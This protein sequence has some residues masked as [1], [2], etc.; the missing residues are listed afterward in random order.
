MRN[1][2]EL[3]EIIQKED[4]MKLFCWLEN[5]AYWFDPGGWLDVKAIRDYLKDKSLIDEEQINNM[6]EEYKKIIT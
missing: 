4:Y 3:K 5:F 1:I 2:D 6:V